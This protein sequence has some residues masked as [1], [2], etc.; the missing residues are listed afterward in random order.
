LVS[1]LLVVFFFFFSTMFMRAVLFTASFGTL[2]SAGFASLSRPCQDS[3]A[4]ILD[5]ADASACI[6]ANQLLNIFLAPA[7]QS[8]IGTTTNW[9]NAF[10]GAAPTCSPALIAHV[11]SQFALACADDLQGLGVS[12]DDVATAL[13]YI[14]QYWSTAK[15]VICLTDTTVG[16]FCAP[17]VATNLQ[18]ALD[19][20]VSVNWVASSIR[21]AVTSH[22]DILP[23]N[24]SCVP[25][26][27]AAFVKVEATELQSVVDLKGFA[28][29]TCG[30]DF[31]AASEMP[32]SVVVG[33]GSSAPTATPNAASTL[34]VAG[35]LSAFVGLLAIWLL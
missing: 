22:I 7:D 34:K 4:G 15:E 14:Q 9:L 31:A 23:A 10:C 32:S 3:L 21:D 6:S 2:V 20:A 29:N 25:C 24:V 5:N 27:Q 18:A 26:T 13:P 1:F 33:I 19:V 17:S 8:M 28:S 30:A 11:T 12:S 35:S 16:E